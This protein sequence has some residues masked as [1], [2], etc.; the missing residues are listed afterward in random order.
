LG[1]L[2]ARV[3]SNRNLEQVKL[4]KNTRPGGGR[5][6][7]GENL[8]SPQVKKDRPKAF[9]EENGYAETTANTMS[10]SGGGTMISRNAQTG[11]EM[12]GKN[13]V[14]KTNNVTVAKRKMDRTEGN[15][16]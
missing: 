1:F 3:L 16:K 9:W 7:Q 13:M 2:P 8:G 12:T 5:I 10:E 14:W 11:F 15:K 6:I 4:G